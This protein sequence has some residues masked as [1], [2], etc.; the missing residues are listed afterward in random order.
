M[1]TEFT[2]REMCLK[3]IRGVIFTEL[4][5]MFIAYYILFRLVIMTTTEIITEFEWKLAK[6]LQ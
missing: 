4:T 2:L 1:V 5:H 6:L 3:N